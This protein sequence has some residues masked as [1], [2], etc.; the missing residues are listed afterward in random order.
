MLLAR[1]N[2]VNKLRSVHMPNTF[3]VSVNISEEILANS[4]R[5]AKIFPC[6][7]PSYNSHV[8]N[9]TSSHS[10]VNYSVLC[11]SSGTA[12]Q[13]AVAVVCSVACGL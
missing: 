4:S 10:H 5:F 9:M 2:L 7:I 12:W 3:C 6:Q 8:S 11:Q 1:K 13:L